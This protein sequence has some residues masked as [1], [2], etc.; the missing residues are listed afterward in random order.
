MNEF[1]ERVIRAIGQPLHR[2]EDLRLITGRGQFSDDIRMDGQA[3]MAVIRSN[4]PHGQILALDTGDARAH[5]GVLAVLTGRE[6]A[7]DGLLPIPHNPLPKTKHDLK[8][9]GP[10][11]TP[12]FIGPHYPLAVDKVRF[13]G[14]PIGIVVADTK[15]QAHDAAELVVP[16]IQELPSISNASAASQPDAPTIWSEIADNVLVETEFGDRIAA[17]KA[18]ASAAHVVSASFH[19]DRVTG[20][21]LEPRAALGYFDAERHRY[22]LFAG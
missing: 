20:V 5:P 17:D 15:Q 4:V 6:L 3:T 11:G 9:T 21:P 18:F 22:S 1:D 2:K 19:I 8:L 12:V 7:A 16:E 14:E 10:G 13:V